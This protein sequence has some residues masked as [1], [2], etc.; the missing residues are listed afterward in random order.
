MSIAII[1]YGSGNLRSAEKAFARV[2]ASLAGDR[3]V[4]V[5]AAPEEVLKADH[6]V[7]PGVGAF[8]DCAE[9]LRAIVG[10]EE[11]LNQR[12]R[13]QAYPFLGICVGMQLI[14]AT[15]H[16]R[17]SHRGFGWIDGAVEP[18]DVPSTLKVPHMGWNDLHITTDNPVFAG[19]HGQDAYFVHGYAAQ[20]VAQNVI[21]ATTDYG[22]PVVAGLACDTIC[23]TQ[24]HPEKSQQTGLHLIAN[25]LEW[26]P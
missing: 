10:M 5:T 2:A 23:G 11:A 12:V 7:L 8:G 17:G 18:L 20:P 19:L 26:K 25:F 3:K 24:F 14:C 13:Q 21:A 9:G 1:D 15:G 6:I 16:E 22:G 4:T